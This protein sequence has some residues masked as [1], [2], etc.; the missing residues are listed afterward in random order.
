MSPTSPAL[1]LR[2][3]TL[4]D[5]AVVSE[6]ERLS[7]DDGWAATAFESELRNNGAARYVLLER[8]EDRKSVV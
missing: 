1:R 7:F 5:L 2:R 6:I 4:D 3:L 8:R